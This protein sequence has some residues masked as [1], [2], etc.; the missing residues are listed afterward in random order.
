MAL[1]SAISGEYI[2]TQEDNGSIRICQI[3]DNIEDSL[4]DAAKFTKLKIDSTWDTVRLG[5]EL[6]SLYGEGDGKRANIGEYTIL[7]ERNGEIETYRVHGNTI[8]S[9]NKIA[10][11]IS[12]KPNPKWDTRIFGSKLIDFVN[13][14]YNPEEEIEE[15]S[16]VVKPEMSVKELQDSFKEMFGGHL[17]IKN[18]NKRCDE[19]TDSSTG[20][21]KDVLDATLTEIGCNA[22]G[23]FP[24]DMTVGE[25]QDKAKSECGLNLVV[26]T[27]DDWVAVL[28]GFT[29]DGVNNIPRNITKAKMEEI[30]NR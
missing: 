30:L 18:G 17:R 21:H 15:V 23:K 7:N 1:K 14:D 24:V 19:F 11:E 5:K 25:F 2:I 8:K 22:E 4:K 28:P 10:E 16:F 13:G 20:Q 6:V 3:F 29:L 26:A 27:S 9:L 12:F